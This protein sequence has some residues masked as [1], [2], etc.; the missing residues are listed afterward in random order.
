[1]KRTMRKARRAVAVKERFCRSSGNVFA[2]L[3]LSHPERLMARSEM[4]S[5]ITEII[6]E[7]RLTQKQAAA[8]LGI[9][10]SK[11][12][13]L[14]NGKLSMFSMDYLLELLNKLNRDVTIIITPKPKKEKAAT[15]RV[16]VETLSVLTDPRAVAGIRRGEADIRAGRTR[17]WASI[18]AEHRL[19]KSQRE[20]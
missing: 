7:R 17:S 15:T 2:D 6:R 9:P 12:S 16:F 8:V 14:M 10:Q 20:G 4:M 1:M 5:R 18:K 11:V 19:R 13:C 3:G